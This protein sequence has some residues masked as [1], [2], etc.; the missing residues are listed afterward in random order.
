MLPVVSGESETFGIKA[1]EPCGPHRPAVPSRVA[2]DADFAE[3]IGL[4]P[5]KTIRSFILADMAGMRRLALLEH[6][7]EK[8][9]DFSV[10]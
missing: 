4:T 1:V 3:D 10:L 5:E 7:P 8:L 2:I 9:S 6:V